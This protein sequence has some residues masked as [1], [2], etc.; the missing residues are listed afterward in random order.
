MD[1]ITDMLDGVLFALGLKEADS[2]T[3]VERKHCT[4]SLITGLAGGWVAGIYRA[5][6]KPTVNMIGF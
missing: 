2:E 4:Y 5:K 3:P 6:T 1:F